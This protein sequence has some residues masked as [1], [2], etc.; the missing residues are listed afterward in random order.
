MLEIDAGPFGD[1]PS[2]AAAVV[3]DGRD[4][5]TIRGLRTPV[6]HN[7]AAAHIWKGPPPTPE[8]KGG[9]AGTS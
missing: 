9:R 3:A 7:V 1:V 8:G 5:L 4:H 2:L 6:V